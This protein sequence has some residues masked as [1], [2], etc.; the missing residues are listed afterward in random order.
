MQNVPTVLLVEDDENDVLFFERALRKV[1]TRYLVRVARNGQEAISYMLGE[2]SFADRERFPLPRFIISDGNM[3]G[4]S[5]HE[6][7][8]WLKQHPEFRVVPTIILAGT[9]SPRSV[10]AAYNELGAHSFIT[11]PSDMHELEQIVRKIFDYW[12]MCRLPEVKAAQ[13]ER[14]QVL[15]A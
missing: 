13:N 4:M 15:H 8:R 3:P 14:H 7:L 5:G 12:S 11:K 10:E 1:N 6:F 2:G 9:D